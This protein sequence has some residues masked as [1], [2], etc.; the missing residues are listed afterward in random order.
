MEISR[1]QINQR[2]LKALQTCLLL[3]LI[4]FVIQSI[5]GKPLRK[6]L[7]LVFINVNVVPMDKE[8]ILSNQIVIIKNGIIAEIG[9]TNNI[10]IPT[11]SKIIDGRGKYLMPGLIDSHVHL[12]S[13]TEMPLYVINGVTTV[14]DLNGK[15]ATL[16]WKK[17]IAD[18]QLK[19]APTIFATGPK[20]DEI[21]KAEEDVREVEAQWKAGYDGIKIYPQISKEEYPALI[22]AA[23]KHQ[24]IIVGHIPR[25]VGLETTLHYGQS[26]AHA[27]EYLYT[28]FNAS[29]SKNIFDD[30]IKLDESRIPQAVAMTRQSGVSVIAT[31]VT[32]DHIVQQTTALENYLKKPELKFIAPY[33]LEKLQPANNVYKNGFTTEEKAT[34]PANLEFQKKLVK[35]L[36]DAGVPVVAGT[37]SMGVG[38]VAGFSLH[39]E[40]NNFVKIGFTPFQA[41]QTATTNASSFLHSSDKFGSVTVGKRADLLLLE[42]NPLKDIKN[43]S[44]IA[45]VMVRGQ[46]LP[47][48]KLR[49]KLPELPSEY[50]R[51][52]QQLITFL[53]NS[54][55]QAV[56]YLNDNDPFGQLG[57]SILKEIV[58]RYGSTRLIKILHEIKRVS[59]DFPLI[60]E[61]SINRLGYLLLNSGKTNAAIEV[62]RLN[63]EFYSQSPNVYD[64]LGE[65]FM[66]SGDKVSAIKNFKKSLELNPQNQNALKMLKKLEN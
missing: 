12:Y 60:S 5:S 33:L 4:C 41:L 56:Q 14:F 22:E 11:N 54:P 50:E 13:E 16:L 62:F 19:F 48:A 20:F 9:E 15:S 45:G 49:Q 27:E 43:V 44:R 10:R 47:Q 30:D 23:K 66:K 46:W 1:D 58:L 21:R 39:E 35:A 51:E 61:T 40:L 34:L 42:D 24:M 59:V 7:V 57:N 32:Y 2:I 8:Q 64:S 65:A 31:L 63:V 53:R 36:F 37:D 29:K 52:K 25:R 17:K 3:S 18:G 26:I 28:F 38:P 6:D 55:G